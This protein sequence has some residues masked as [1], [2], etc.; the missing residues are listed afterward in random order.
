MHIKIL[1][2]IKSHVTHVIYE[3]KFKSLMSF[4]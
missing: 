2:N 1:K 3:L 4:I